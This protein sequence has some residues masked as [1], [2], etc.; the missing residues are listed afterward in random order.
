MKPHTSP[1]K[2]RL[3]RWVVLAIVLIAAAV[4]IV[5]YPAVFSNLDLQHWLQH[6]AEQPAAKSSE[7]QARLVPGSSDEIELPPEVVERLG[8]KSAPVNA[9]AAPRP[10]TLAGSLFF[11][12]NKLGSVQPRFPGEVLGAAATE[13]EDSTRVVVQ[14]VKTVSSNYHPSSRTLMIRGYFLIG[15]LAKVVRSAG[16][17]G[18]E[19]LA[20]GCWFPSCNV[21]AGRARSLKNA[22]GGLW[23]NCQRGPTSTFP[24]TWEPFVS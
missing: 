7:S 20:R 24:H 21:A 12:P 10:L 3:L 11:E 22:S 2:W 15:L 5:R 16:Q 9:A 6:T 19:R 13:G 18:A 14:D 8:V 23:L 1:G 4:L 17:D